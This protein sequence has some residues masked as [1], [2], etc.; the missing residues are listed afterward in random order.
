MG[1]FRA[2]IRTLFDLSVYREVAEQRTRRTVGYFALVVL[3]ASLIAATAAT[4]AVHKAID[5]HVV[6]ELDK[7]PVVT[8]KNHKASANVP[9]PWVKSFKPDDSN[10]NSMFV[11]DTTGK[12]TGFA[13]NEQ[14]LILTRDA[15]L[16]KDAQKY[17]EQTFPLHGVGD[18]VIDAAYVRS[19]IGP[20]L[21]ICFASVFAGGL[22][23]YTAAKL[24][25]ALLLTLVGLIFA[26]GRRRPLSFGTIYSLSI[27]AL[28]P[29]IL[30]DLGQMF[31]GFHIPALWAIYMLIGAVYTALAV[32]AIPDHDPALP[33]ENPRPPTGFQPPGVQA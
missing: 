22:F 28:T 26:S 10:L 21:K 30:L 6:P 17:R 19:W 2:M 15:V 12:T 27:Y 23:W 8:I 16:I 31:V 7:L 1:H 5:Q 25:Q 13:A 32:R 18:M 3:I 24:F 29:A 9:Q 14:G 20:A 33:F 4:L 11:I